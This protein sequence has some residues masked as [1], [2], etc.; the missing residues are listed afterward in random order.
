[1][2]ERKWFQVERNKISS[3][4]CT[5]VLP[6]APVGARPGLGSKMLQEAAMTLGCSWYGYGATSE[7]S[8]ALRGG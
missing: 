2:G 5:A 3:Y 7:A 1:M 4:I 8:R 6:A